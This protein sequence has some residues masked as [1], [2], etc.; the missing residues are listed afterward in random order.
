MTQWLKTSQ[1]VKQTVI[2]IFF[3]KTNTFKKEC[4]IKALQD[5]F[6]QVSCRK[7]GSGKH[8][9]WKHGNMNTR[10]MDT[11]NHVACTQYPMYFHVP[12]KHTKILSGLSKI[13]RCHLLLK[14]KDQ[15][16]FISFYTAWSRL[17]LVQQHWLNN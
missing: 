17:D 2:Y 12:P 5:Q 13:R 3:I 10:N 8:E 7:W 11:D 14:S 4:V 9:H 1:Q 16:N 6:K 15:I